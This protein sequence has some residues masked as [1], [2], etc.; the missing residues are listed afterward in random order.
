ML[1]NYRAVTQSD[2]VVDSE[3]TASLSFTCSCSGGDTKSRVWKMAYGA[4]AFELWMAATEL[5]YENPNIEL[6][7]VYPC[8]PKRLEKLAAMLDGKQLPELD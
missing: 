8:Y 6:S 4:L 1:S 2:V 5:I 7:K 3:N